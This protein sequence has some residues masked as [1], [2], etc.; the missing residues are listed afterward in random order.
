M[1]APIASPGP[2]AEQVR[3][4]LSIPALRV[5]VE[6]LVN[7]STQHAASSDGFVSS[8][9]EMRRDDGQREDPSW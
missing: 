6:G 2:P 5:L 7:G 1:R 9:E 4:A 3:G 8:D